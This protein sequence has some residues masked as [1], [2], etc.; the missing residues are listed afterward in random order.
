MLLNNKKVLHKDKLKQNN[1][2]QWRQNTL[3]IRSHGFQVQFCLLLAQL[4]WVIY[5]TFRAS[6]SQTMK[7][8]TAFFF[9]LCYAYTKISSINL[10]QLHIAQSCKCTDLQDYTCEV[11]EET[12]GQD[13][14][15]VS[16]SSKS[17]IISKP[18]ANHLVSGTSVF[19]I[20]K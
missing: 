4:P 18:W 12:H 19:S 3:V 15:Q 6:I 14:A 17:P 1:L 7:Q 13:R 10:F 2:V 16:V 5:L 8:H 9:F 11:K 20:Q